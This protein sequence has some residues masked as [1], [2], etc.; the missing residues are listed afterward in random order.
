[1]KQLLIILIFCFIL[2]NLFGQQIIRC[3]TEKSEQLRKQNNPE[4]ENKEIFEKWI[5]KKINLNKY[6]ASI[7]KTSEVTYVIPVVVHVIHNGESI[8][9][10]SNI[11]DAII[12]SQIQ[13]LNDDYKRL[14]ADTS[15]TRSIFK[16][17]AAN[18]N[19]QFQLALTDPDGF[20]TSGITRLKGTKTSWDITDNE[21][22][23]SLSYW[24]SSQYLNIWVCA[25]S[26]RNLGYAQYPESNLA[27]LN[28][29]DLDATAYN[30]AKNALTDGIV[31]KYNA[32]GSYASPYPFSKGRTS[33]HE[34]GHYL[35][36][37]H[38]WGDVTDCT[39]TDYCSDTP[40]LLGSSNGCDL[41][42]KACDSIN[43]AMIE[44]Y[45]DY[46]DDNCMNIFT[47]QQK[48]RMRTVLQ[49][50][51]R[52][53]SLLT[54]PG[55]S[56]PA[57]TANDAGIKAIISP[58]SL[59]YCQN[60]IEVKVV[61]KNFG[62]NNLTNV[63]I[64]YQ[65]DNLSNIKYNWIGN[66]A[67]SFNDTIVLTNI[68]LSVG[69]HTFRVNTYL[70]NGNPDAK[71]YNDTLKS[72]FSINQ[73]QTLPFLVDFNDGVFPPKGW[74]LF[75]PDLQTTWKDTIAGGSLT[76]NNLSAYINMFDYNDNGQQQQDAL[77]SPGYD[78]SKI[79]SAT[80][81][82]KISYAQADASSNDG[83]KILVSTDCGNTYNY[84]LYE[85]YGSELA[86]ASMFSTAWRPKHLS[87]WKDQSIDLHNFIG[88]P[89]VNLAFVSINGYGNNLYLDDI[90]VQLITG[91]EIDKE[92]NNIIIVSP[93]PND[94]NFSIDLNLIKIQDINVEI[95]DIVG[96]VVWNSENKKVLKTNLPIDLSL[97]KSGMYFVNIKGE[98]FQKTTKIIIY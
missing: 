30:Q 93:N 34:V 66:L 69:N 28:S 8:G 5:L 95:T 98:N 47:N 50:S 32:F 81:L 12:N 19:I 10:G 18:C 96:K 2:T 16:P 89:S 62:N 63:E 27:G 90:Q 91:T 51:P 65:I 83:F 43:L 53:T 37:R 54:S 21:T 3:S 25:L 80:L 57:L 68:N 35:G 86:T 40:N 14:N 13:V 4:I 74:T 33:T 52:R 76:S 11:S 97:I 88:M 82:F 46:S 56:P 39:G 42:K 23:K 75:N 29:T 24:N 36:L 92:N 71:K 44:N 7:F 67:S 70:P 84:T 59:K 26:G 48:L 60:Q 79:S 73:T 49:N 77:Y 20:P 9:S 78:F 6:Y 94:G 41:A 1:M 22:L 64:D 31:I 87:D 85:K 17:V 45:L 55:L 58:S 61:L 15:K 38:T 72:I